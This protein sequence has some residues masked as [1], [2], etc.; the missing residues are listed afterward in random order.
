MYFS[1]S[2]TYHLGFSKVLISSKKWYYFQYQLLFPISDVG[3]PANGK[4]D[5]KKIVAWELVNL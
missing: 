5:K 4:D 3:A 2:K 1:K